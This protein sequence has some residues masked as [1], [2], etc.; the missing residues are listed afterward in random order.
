MLTELDNISP[1]HSSDNLLAA[2][3][4]YDK[5][6]TAPPGGGMLNQQTCTRRFTVLY[7]HCLLRLSAHPAK[8]QN[9]CH[10]TTTV[11]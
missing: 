3:S 5:F 9:F 8:L 10:L 11:A 4:T 6:S 2:D 7:F 1:K